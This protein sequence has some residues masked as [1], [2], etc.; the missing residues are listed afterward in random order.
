MGMFDYVKSS[1][2]LPEP[3]MGVNQTKDIEDVIGGTLGEYWI[4]PSG[5]LWCP[6]FTGALDFVTIDE[7]DPDWSDK[8]HFLNYK[9]VPTGEHGKM[10]VVEITKYIEIYPQEWDGKWEDWPRCRLHFKNGKLQDWQEVTG[11]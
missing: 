11:Q 4:D 7:T 5:V 9:W 3:F 1:Y 8:L 6:S 10:R 2:P